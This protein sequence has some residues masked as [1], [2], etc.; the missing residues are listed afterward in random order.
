MSQC[1]LALQTIYWRESL[2]W[3]QEAAFDGNTRIW[4]WRGTAEAGPFSV[5]NNW[6]IPKS[7]LKLWI[8][9]H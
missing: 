9:K 7:Y 3:L 2:T 1:C 4:K 5:P 6:R 8:V